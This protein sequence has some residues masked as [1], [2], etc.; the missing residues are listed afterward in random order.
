M[1]VF[2][3]EALGVLLCL[4]LQVKTDDASIRISASWTS[5]CSR[6]D[7]DAYLA[8]MKGHTEYSK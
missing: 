3:A 1:L 8:M 7:V 2:V 4:C 5:L 6:V